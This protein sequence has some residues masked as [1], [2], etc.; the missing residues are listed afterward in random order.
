M[1]TNFPSLS[2]ELAQMTVCKAQTFNTSKFA[3]VINSYSEFLSH[4]CQT[5][6]FFPKKLPKN[7]ILGIGKHC[8]VKD[9]L[10][11][12]RG[13]HTNLMGGS[14]PKELMAMAKYDQVAVTEL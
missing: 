2:E 7:T 9:N 3:T 1:Q 13:H 10:V 8:I 5:R 6:W 12:K 11:K 14:S 4:N